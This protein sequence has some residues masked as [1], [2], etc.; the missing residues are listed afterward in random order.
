MS[1]DSEIKDYGDFEVVEQRCF[2]G[3]KISTNDLH[4]KV[5]IVEF[6][7]VG[8]SKKKIG[9][10]CTTIQIIYEEKKRIIFTSSIGLRNRLEQLTQDR[11]PFRAM[12]VKEND[13]L[14]FT[15]PPPPCQ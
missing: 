3:P 14:K 5:V 8:P 4:N 2:V 11:F 10:L 7:E 15:K 13:H 1:I 12:I 9:T 6:Y